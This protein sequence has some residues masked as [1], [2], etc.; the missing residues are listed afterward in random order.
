MIRGGIYYEA[1]PSSKECKGVIMSG[2]PVVLVSP[3]PWGDVVQVV[4]L[5]TSA[6]RRTDGFPHHIPVML[7][8]EEN[9]AL[10]EQVRTVDLSYLKKR[11]IGAVSTQTLC[12]IDAQLK[13]ILGLEGEA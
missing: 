9:V 12:E 7:G 11:L 3:R 1:A 2:R 4:P 10:C 13:R 5:T 8:E 6:K